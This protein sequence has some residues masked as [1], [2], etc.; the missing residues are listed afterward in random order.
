MNLSNSSYTNQILR[1]LCFGGKHFAHFRVFGEKLCP[2]KH[3]LRTEKGHENIFSL[4]KDNIHLSPPNNSFTPKTPIPHLW[5]SP[6]ITNCHPSLINHLKLQ[7]YVC[8][9]WKPRNLIKTQN[10]ENPCSHFI[11]AT[12]FDGKFTRNAPKLGILFYWI[13]VFIYDF[14]NTVW[15]QNS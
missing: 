2:R 4:H 12:F 6:H 5:P 3:F 7:F 13:H 10:Q 11:Q 9:I 8:S 1:C 14:V 15:D